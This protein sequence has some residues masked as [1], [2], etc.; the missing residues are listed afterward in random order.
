LSD[1]IELY[2]IPTKELNKISSKSGRYVENA[3]DKNSGTC[4]FVLAKKHIK[5]YLIKSLDKAEYIK[6]IA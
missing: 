1:I 5:D 3:G 2:K 4:G 6:N